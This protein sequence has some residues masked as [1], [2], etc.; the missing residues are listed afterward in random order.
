MKTYIFAF[1]LV[2][3]S[4]SMFAQVKTTETRTTTDSTGNQVTT[5]SVIISK[6]EDITPRSGMITI[7]PLKFFLFYNLTFYTRLSPQTAIGFGFQTPTLAGIDG[8]GINA[9]FR[10]YP[11]R[12]SP[13]GF[14]F[15][16]N[17]SY[18]ELRTE[19]TKTTPYSI[20]ALIGWQ[21]FPGDDFAMGLGLGVDYYKGSSTSNGNDLGKYDGTVPAVR[22]DIGY[23]W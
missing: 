12:K 20:G 19:N 23:G 1:L 7:N 8:F 5:S 3:L 13:R 15:A 2:L 21:W 9:E 4:T 14:Y 22:F 16:P 6:S 11:S 10:I 17:F 18:N